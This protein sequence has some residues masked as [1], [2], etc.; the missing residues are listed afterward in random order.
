[1]EEGSGYGSFSTA[2]TPH[3]PL[4]TR[5]SS[6]TKD[7][8]SDGQ[9]KRVG[10]TRR[11]PLSAMETRQFVRRRVVLGAAAAVAAMACVATRQHIMSIREESRSW[12]VDERNAVGDEMAVHE[13]KIFDEAT[14]R[15]H[16]QLGERVRT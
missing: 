10:C 16:S 7:V 9:M 13:T 4:H 6:L 15:L 3:T 12:S 2:P 5:Q 14:L 11:R 1:M 8:E